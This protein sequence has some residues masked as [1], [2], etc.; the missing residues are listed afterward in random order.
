MIRQNPAYSLKL[1]ERKRVAV[2]ARVSREGEWKH[3]SIE[4]QKENLRQYINQ[5]ANWEFVDFYVDEGVSGTKMNRPAFNRLLRDAREHKVDIILTKTVSRLGR[6]IKAVLKVLEE[7]RELGVTVIFDNDHLNT[8][9]PDHMLALQ[10]LGVQA[11]DQARR[12]SEYQRWAIR[13]RFKEG[14]PTYT[15]LYGYEM[16]DHQLIVVPEEAEVVKRIFEMYLSGMGVKAISKK[17][18][19]EH[20]PKFNEANWTDSTIHKMIRNEKYMGDMLLQ[21]KYVSDYLTKTLKVNHGEL[22]QYYVVES[23]EPIISK[24][25]FEK[26]QAEIERRNKLYHKQIKGI[27]DK[28]SERGHRLFS[29]L[30]FCGH[31]HKV[32]FY[33]KC[34]NGGYT[35]KVWV[36]T[37][38]ME[39][40]KDFCPVYSIRED[41]LIKV[42]REVLE[43]AGL[44]KQDMKLTN[45][46]LKKYIERIYA[47]ENHQLEYHLLNGEII[48]KTWAYESRSKSWTPEMREEARKRATIE[49]AMRRKQKSIERSEVC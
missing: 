6:N 12:V 21:K 15:R 20:V 42:T 46:L 17:L 39:L 40:G 14:I 43:E 47:N 35:R 23:H 13:N 18:N 16:K 31:C 28:D 27:K 36:C 48:T 1:L 10:M 11:E 7:L 25:T 49:N 38:Y 33:K 22:P 29:Q 45:E 37:D 30:L 26:V 4:A 34:L 44:I 41:I 9:D 3:R 5:H 24:E 8:A 32:M 19:E 2:Y